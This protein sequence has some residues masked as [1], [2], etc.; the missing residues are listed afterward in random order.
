VALPAALSLLICYICVSFAPAGAGGRQGGNTLD[1]QFL[2]GIFAGTSM[3]ANVDKY[4]VVEKGGFDITNIMGGFRKK[5]GA[6]TH[7]HGAGIIGVILF[8]ILNIFLFALFAP[9]ITGFKFL[10]NHL[11]PYWDQRKIYAEAAQRRKEAIETGEQYPPLLQEKDVVP[12]EEN[13]Q[14]PTEEYR[15]V[16][17]DGTT[18]EPQP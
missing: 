15:V 6:T 5:V 17:D 1:K 14:T 4:D 3:G 7:F 13:H 10:E 9:F 2:A 12:A 11:L 16:V 8:T 18:T